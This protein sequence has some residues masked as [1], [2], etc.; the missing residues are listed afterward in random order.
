MVGAVVV[1][2]DTV[3][4]RG[5][6]KVFGGPHAEV[7]ALEG[8]ADKAKGA[9]LYVTLEPCC[10]Y[11]KTPP[12]ADLIIKRRVGRVVIGTEDP[13]PL[14]AGRG[15]KILRDHGIIV[16][17]GV[18]GQE[19][20]QLNA[21]FFKYFEKG[22]PFVT[23]KMAQSIDGRI[24]TRQGHSRWISSSGSLRLAHRWRA[25]HDAVMVG[26]DTVI[27]DNPS[28]TVRLVRG[29]NPLRLVLDSRLRLPLESRILADGHVS[30]TIVVTTDRADPHQRREIQNRGARVLAVQSNSTGQVD[31]TAALRRLAG[32]GITSI[33][34]E[35]GG[36]L[37][38]A[39]V[40]ARLV[41]QIVLVIGSKIIGTGIEAMGDLGISDMNEAVR[42][43]IDKIRRVGD[44]LIVMARIRPTEGE[45]VS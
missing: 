10:H 1:R 30:R 38:T 27:A 17:I 33:L 32:E 12:C 16:D 34:V 20:H 23:L 19:C 5:Y 40:K 14:V 26:V 15:I 21:P 4:G 35:G 11:G 13:N 42:L 37:S 9:T 8:L 24:A 7:N 44:D 6:H 22:L 2:G 25:I 39:F 36:K 31:L 29:K 28:L 43:S 3:I 18:L 45:K 41:D